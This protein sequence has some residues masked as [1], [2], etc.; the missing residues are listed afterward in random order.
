MSG[1]LPFGF[2]PGDPDDDRDKDQGPGF[3]MS[4][5][6]EMLQQLGSMMQGAMSGS[7]AA[8]GPVN[9]ELANDTARKLLVS[10]GDPSITDGQRSATETAV[11]LAEVWLDG[12]TEF[13]AAGGRPA[14]W[15]RS[16]WLQATLPAWQEII[17]P[18]A[19]RV[20]GSMGSLLPGS[21]EGGLP[22]IPGLPEGLP[23]EISSMLGPLMGMA[24][25]MGATMFAMQAAQGLAGLAS[26]VL[27]AS[28][29][30]IP[31]T[32]DGRPA[33]LPGNIRTF[34]EGLGVPE[35]DT[36]VFLALR[37]AAHQRLFAHVPWLRSRMAAAVDAYARG[38]TVDTERIEQAMSGIDPTN[39]AA[40]QE[41]L[42]SGVFMGEDT[43]QQKN[44]LASLE[45]LLALV[46]GWVQVVVAEAVGDRLESFGQLQE[47]I[48]RRRAA[49]GPAERT[50]ATLVGLEM[51]PRK[52]REAERLWRAL[53]EARGQDGRDALWA[54][55]D[56]LP[57]PEDLE[58][59]EEFIAATD[60]A[61]IE[62]IAS[63]FEAL[64]AESM[65]AQTP[66]DAA[67]AAETP[68]AD[69]DVDV[70]VEQ[71]DDEDDAGS[72]NPPRA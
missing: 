16:E 14:A 50:F 63:A 28:D 62:D 49:G 69:E 23:A 45:T 47:A 30:G 5:I 29:V 11:D 13:P 53:G 33:L 6:G 21:G 9:W 4:Q 57:T 35:R 61:M 36:M 55:P 71:D 2:T 42:S 51:R 12:A 8:A 38:I 10:Q 54:H 56:L 64:A 70:E 26:E 39:P 66:E 31:L 34:G 58:R 46:E 19:E 41:I 67:L 18:I 1:N 44:A 52:L 72:D 25:Q 68:D 17:N 7:G 60:P 3:D 20:Q 43:P 37:E 24:K 59:P 32:D 22:S 27:S 48:L 15:S 40:M 65:A